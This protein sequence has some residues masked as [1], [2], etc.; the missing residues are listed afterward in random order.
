MF[1]MTHLNDCARDNRSR[2]IDE[3]NT[4]YV[5]IRVSGSASETILTADR[6][7]RKWRPHCGEYSRQRASDE[8]EPNAQSSSSVENRVLRW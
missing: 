7:R 6:E 2:R 5:N 4:K 1:T 3:K 8:H